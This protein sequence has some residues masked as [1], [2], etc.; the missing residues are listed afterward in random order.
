MSFFKKYLGGYFSIGRLT[1]S[2]FN[3]M[4]VAFSFHTYRWGYL[5]FH[6]TVRMNGYWWRW[7]FYASPNGTPWAS[8]FAIGPGLD[9]VDKASAPLRRLI[10]GH[11]YNPDQLQRGYFGNWEPKTATIGEVSYE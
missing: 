4:H 8:T 6:P 3:A 11:N 2:G 9:P 1:V 5:C 10:L 7:Y